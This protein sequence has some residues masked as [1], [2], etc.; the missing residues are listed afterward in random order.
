MSPAP[1]DTQEASDQEL[2]TAF[3]REFPAKYKEYYKTKRQNF[4]ASVDGFR[5]LWGM[6]MAVDAI[7]LRDLEDLS[8]ARDPARTF[9]IALYMNAHAK[10]RIA[11]E[12]AFYGCLSEARSVLRDA[13]ECV[14][15][16]HYMLTDPE[17]QKVWLCKED[18]KASKDAF[19]RAFE[20]EKKER[21]FY[22]LDELHGI[23]G[24]LSETGSHATV[25]AMCDRMVVT[26]T[27]E[28]MN[29][30]VNYCGA[31][32]KTAAT[33]IFTMLLTCHVMERTLYSDYETRLQLDDVLLRMRQEFDRKK[34]AL[35]HKII[36]RY[37]I[38]PPQR[39]R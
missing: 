8:T 26:E 4:H 12:L 24:E 7:F 16:A 34:E 37:N 20:K 25:M 9:P 18:D 6:Y 31:E 2:L 10:M 38:Q 13:I 39:K 19:T 27:K 17:L 36:K 35:R 22:G 1:K 14:A 3:E 29:F 28:G 23:Y 15:H 5:E 33:S 32:E 21:L 30:Q 11:M